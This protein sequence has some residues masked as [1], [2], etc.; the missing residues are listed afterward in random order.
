MKTE[1]KKLV[2]WDINATTKTALFQ[3]VADEFVKQGL[4]DSATML[5]TLLNQREAAG[6][7]MIDDQLAAPHAQ[8]NDLKANTLVLVHTRQPIAHWDSDSDAQ[9]FI[10]CCIRQDIT[11]AQAHEMTKTLQQAVAPEMAVLFRQATQLQIMNKL[12]F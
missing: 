7:T 9:N 3:Q 8:T 2:M 1:L 4:L 11:K 6:S 12:R 5:I 10:C